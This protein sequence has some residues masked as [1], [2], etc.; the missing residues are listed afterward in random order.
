MTEAVVAIDMGNED[1]NRDVL[2]EWFDANK[3]EHDGE[4]VKSD[5]ERISY[6]YYER[7]GVIMFKFDNNDDYFPTVIIEYLNSL[8]DKQGTNVSVAEDG[9]YGYETL[10]AA[11]LDDFCNTVL[12]NDAD[13]GED[14]L[15]GEYMSSV[16]EYLSAIVGMPP[17]AINDML[18]HNEEYLNTQYVDGVSIEDVAKE[19]LNKE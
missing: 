10:I 4:Y 3:Y 13:S 2:D 5:G 9:E 16:A 15:F 7:V 6:S 8:T 12:V 18:S 14:N 19:I 17:T 1:M 11:S